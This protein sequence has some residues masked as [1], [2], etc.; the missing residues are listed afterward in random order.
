MPTA[1]WCLLLLKA[2]LPISIT[3]NS[4][5]LRDYFDQ[6]QTENPTKILPSSREGLIFNSSVKNVVM[7]LRHWPSDVATR[8]LIFPEEKESAAVKS[9][10]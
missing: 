5:G 3:T 10:P 9:S 2:F 7:F 4:K 8:S 6:G 1:K